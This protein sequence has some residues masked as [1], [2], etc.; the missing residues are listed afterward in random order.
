MERCCR[1]RGGRIAIVSRGCSRDP[2]PVLI[3][4]GSP[5]SYV[6]PNG[7]LWAI[8]Q[9]LPQAEDPL[10]RTVEFSKSGIPV[11]RKDELLKVILDACEE[12]SKA[13][14]E[15]LQSKKAGLGA[16]ANTGLLVPSGV[17]VPSISQDLASG[18]DGNPSASLSRPSASIW[19]TG[20]VH[21]T[22]WFCVLRLSALISSLYRR[23]RSHSGRLNSSWKYYQPLR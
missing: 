22:C 15:E 19:A 7:M 1:A 6:M 17:V 12:G 21:S 5:R 14:L 16:G 20:S 4:F 3:L 9:R 13:Y 10:L 11:R 2:P 18:L 8:V 23:H